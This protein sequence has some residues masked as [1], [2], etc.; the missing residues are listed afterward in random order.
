MVINQ[1]KIKAMAEKNKKATNGQ[2]KKVAVNI[3]KPAIIDVS[4]IAKDKYAKKKLDTLPNMQS[5]RQAVL[6]ELIEKPNKFLAKPIIKKPLS[7]KIVSQ[8]KLSIKDLEQGK[9]E[10][11][12]KKIKVN[13]RKTSRKIFLTLLI[14]V[15]IIVAAIANIY[16]GQINNPISG[17]IVKHLPLP[18]I[19]IN[20]QIISMADFYCDYSALEKFTQR[21]DMPYTE[22]NLKNKVF[23]TLIEKKILNDLAV[24]ENINVS[25]SEINNQL[26]DVLEN[27]QEYAN[28]SDLIQNLYGWDLEQYKTK[29]LKPL[30][31]AKKLSEKFTY[32]SGEPELKEA[33]NNFSIKI[34]ED[35]NQFEKIAWTVNEDDTRY[36]AG[37]LGWLQLGEIAP[38]LELAL[39][40]LKEGEVSEL[41]ESSYGYHLIK[42]IEISENDNG[43]P[44]FHAAHIFLKK[45]QF[46]DYLDNEIKKAK[47]LSL[48]KL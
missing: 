21:Q 31:I 8:K 33:L 19:F 10:K 28:A 46:S 35:S 3:N 29:I 38:D 20:G 41:V 13:V 15:I 44:I 23:Q 14:A 4:K 11:Q 24:S 32:Q 47:V 6:N 2:I 16:F 12:E 1:I 34:K 36:T 39:L 40:G 22:L 45:K 43:S 30:A 25:E 18:A 37:D 27:G 17:F 26:N 5:I 48:I 9:T 7:Q 42:M